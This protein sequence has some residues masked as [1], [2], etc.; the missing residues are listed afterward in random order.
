M[1]DRPTRISAGESA[2]HRWLTAERAL[3][4]ALRAVAHR[5][6]GYEE[7][8]PEPKIRPEVPGST[9][10]C[11]IEIGPTIAVDGIHHRGGFVAG[12][13]QRPALTVHGGQQAGVQVDLTPLGAG[14][15]FA[16]D[17]AGLTDRV[18]TLDDLLPRDWR[19]L[20]PRLASLADWPSRLATV[21]AF[22]LER[23]D[24]IEGQPPWIEWAWGRI[25]ATGGEIAMAELAAELGYSTRHVN[26]AFQAAVGLSPKRYALLVRFERLLALL[27]HGPP[28]SWAERAAR[29]GYADQAHLAREVRR[30]TGETPSGLLRIRQPFARQP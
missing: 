27:D 30:F 15:I 8:T 28:S 2:G 17:L 10:T 5:V 16:E 9:I 22:L 21:E 11:I 25:H 7:R 23:L 26:R 18:V 24:R 29:V 13:H 1:S 6:V 3:H 19:A 12:L 20:G 4:P 14:R